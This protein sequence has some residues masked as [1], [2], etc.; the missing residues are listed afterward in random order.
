MHQLRIVFDNTRNRQAVRQEQDKT[1]QKAEAVGSSGAITGFML[2][3]VL[4]AK[5]SRKRLLA[6]HVPF[7]SC[8]FAAVDDDTSNPETAAMYY[9]V[10]ASVHA[11]SCT[12]ETHLVAVV[13]FCRWCWRSLTVI[14]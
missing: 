6:L 9:N 8:A 3:E 12:D 1:W 2:K 13:D 4:N 14:T 7:T 11:P 5:L 10:P